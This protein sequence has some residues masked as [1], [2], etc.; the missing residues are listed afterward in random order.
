[1]TLTY[2][3]IIEE[4][5]VGDM[6]PVLPM[7]TA[8]T[9]EDSD[10]ERDYSHP[11]FTANP[12]PIN[13]LPKITNITLTTNEPNTNVDLDSETDKGTDELPT[14]L[15]TGPTQTPMQNPAGITKDVAETSGLKD[16]TTLNMDKTSHL[17][18]SLSTIDTIIK[19]PPASDNLLST[20]LES[21]PLSNTHKNNNE[22]TCKEKI[23]IFEN[24]GNL[25]TDKPTRSSISNVSA[26]AQNPP[27]ITNRENLNQPPS[28]SSVA[29]STRTNPRY[30][31]YVDTNNLQPSQ[32]SYAKFNLLLRNNPKHSLVNIMER[33]VD[34]SGYILTFA[35][36]EAAYAF[37][38][39]GFGGTDLDNVIIRPTSK[40]NIREDIIIHDVPFDITNDD[41]ELL[42]ETD[43][44]VNVH[45]TY[46]LTRRNFNNQI[47]ERTKLV[48]ITI[49]KDHANLFNDKIK[50][51]PREYKT[52]KP[53][54]KPV[55]TQCRKCLK[56]GHS[57][58]QCRSN[59]TYC[60]KC[61]G[62]HLTTQ[63]QQDRLIK[64]KNCYGTD[65][66]ATSRQC[67]MHKEIF[68]QLREQNRKKY[69]QANP[70][71]T[72][73]S[74]TRQPINTRSQQPQR[75][76]NK[77]QPN[78]L[79]APQPYSNLLPPINRTRSLATNAEPS[80]N[81]HF[82]PPFNRNRPTARIAEPTHPD[83][84]HG[85]PHRNPTAPP[86]PINP[87]L[88]SSLDFPDLPPPAQFR[89][90]PDKPPATRT[91][92]PTPSQG[93]T[94]TLQLPPKPQRTPRRGR[95]LH[96]TPTDPS[97]EDID[98]P[99]NNNY[100]RLQDKM[101]NDV[102]ALNNNLKLLTPTQLKENR[103]MDQLIALMEFLLT[104]LT[105]MREER[106][107]SNAVSSIFTTSLENVQT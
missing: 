4:T 69:N 17:P 12:L 89:N 82:V 106:Q 56:Y 37:K 70:T 65:H 68:N 61:A 16:T 38:D 104:R 85:L 88:N 64:C 18:N 30:K 29:R 67:P 101:I 86:L 99:F 48:K 3:T 79:Y 50:I 57:T 33:T 81:H 74:I 1:M 20:R 14:N 6:T 55:V 52:T 97:Y 10:G 39:A 100:N 94:Q 66:E 49:D 45:S 46:R 19:Q 25:A 53:P 23:K 31:L 77:T 28:T 105:S 91:L 84:R 43:Y 80:P 11:V 21:Q 87:N 93:P 71:L 103:L 35:N 7:I 96:S 63:C 24:L 47:T 27:T 41:I 73:A 78:F 26:K 90:N 51:G 42:I 54:P 107:T 98:E 5:L 32:T 8:T 59:I 2:D 95:R 76:A 102:K 44:H 40:P 15:I 72:Y 83:P 92:L 60:A 9:S 58:N 34:R 36:R 75:F 13:N 22:S 62:P